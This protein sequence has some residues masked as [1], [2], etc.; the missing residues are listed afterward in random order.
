MTQEAQLL[1]IA[2][3]VGWKNTKW[4]DGC[5][6]LPNIRG[7]WADHPNLNREPRRCRT[8]DYLGDLNV[9]EDFERIISTEGREDEYLQRLSEEVKSDGR[10]C[11]K[12][13]EADHWACAT[14]PAAARA[15]AFLRVM[16]LWVG[17]KSEKS[18]KS[19][20]E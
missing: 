1:A 9:C 5:E 4:M 10:I 15:R 12:V 6:E 18:E 19:E 7:V 20:G 8:P 3:A 2:A 11:F 14:A 16:D 13:S 17:E